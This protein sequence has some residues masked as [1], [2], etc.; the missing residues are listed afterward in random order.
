MIL[1]IFLIAQALLANACSGT[2]N[3]AELIAAQGVYDSTNA[4]DKQWFK[5]D[6]S[7]GIKIQG[8]KVVV[9][10]IS[11]NLWDLDQQRWVD[12]P[13]EARSIVYLYVIKT[14][15]NKFMSSCYLES[16]LLSDAV[17][18][19]K[20]T[21]TGTSIEG[22][23]DLKQ[24]T[25]MRLTLIQTTEIADP[26]AEDLL[27]TCHQAF[28]MTHQEKIKQYYKSML[29]SSWIASSPTKCSTQRN[30]SLWRSKFPTNWGVGEAV[31]RLNESLMV[32][33]CQL[34]AEYGQSCP[35]YLTQF[36][37]SSKADLLGAVLVSQKSRSTLLCAKPGYSCLAT[38]KGNEGFLTSKC[39]PELEN[40]HLRQN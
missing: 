23:L 8:N 25:A 19:S 7:D 20:I 18:A 9:T 26:K 31:C 17:T 36:G 3:L 34:E 6:F 13:I 16:Y 24:K 40:I 15:N 14:K 5:E 29:I 2:S 32:N 38:S 1:R 4:Y 22:I 33:T 37:L 28:S 39:L 10:K 21:I 12:T 35:I 30:C 27:N 11:E